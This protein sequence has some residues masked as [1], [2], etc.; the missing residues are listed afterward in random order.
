MT[1]IG[2]YITPG[3][4]TT[5]QTL[6]NT[7]QASTDF[8]SDEQG[9]ENPGSKPIVV[10]TPSRYLNSDEGVVFQDRIYIA[11]FTLY[12]GSWGGLETQR[13]AWNW[14]HLAERGIATLRRVASDGTTRYLKARPVDAKWTR[15][16]HSYKVMQ[17]Y[18]AVDPWW[19][20]PVE[21]YSGTF[22][23]STPVDIEV[24][25][26][27]QLSVPPR[28][29]CTG[30]VH[31]PKFTNADGEVI[32]VNKATANADDIMQIDCRHGH[33]KVAYWEHGTNYDDESLAAQ[34]YNWRTNA[35]KFWRVPAGTE[36][37][38]IVGASGETST[39]TCA[40]MIQPLYGS[41]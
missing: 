19:Y 6:Y 17:R 5:E 41:L 18:Y 1:V 15:S 4:T 38:T 26:N 21:T 7:V 25:N 32:E 36:D 12:A 24:T 3:D 34:W 14:T 29:K 27:G 33:S 20:G 28:I 39:A 8:L 40:V 16:G 23:G 13:T 9:W 22:N 10:E 37:V 2:L 30:V 11:T 31:T 35:T